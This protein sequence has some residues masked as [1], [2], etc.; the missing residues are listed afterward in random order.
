MSLLRLRYLLGES[1]MSVVILHHL[2]LLTYFPMWWS[3]TDRSIHE[4]LCLFQS[5]EQHVL[6]YFSPM[7]RSWRIRRQKNRRIFHRQIIFNRWFLS[8]A[9]SFWKIQR[10]TS[11]WI[12][13]FSIEDIHFNCLDSMKFIR[14]ICLSIDLDVEC[15]L[16]I[17]LWS[18]RIQHNYTFSSKNSRIIKSK[19]ATTCTFISISS[20]VYVKI[21]IEPLS[22]NKFPM[23]EH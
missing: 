3:S 12:L 22:I 19:N 21:E 20:S 4:D 9:F 15:Q 5:I 23:N 10:R 14:W 16:I 11:Q 8:N 6:I 7:I 18:F 2:S 1:N 17:G 13:A